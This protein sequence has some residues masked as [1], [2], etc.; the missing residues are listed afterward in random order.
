MFGNWIQIGFESKNPQAPHGGWLFGN[1]ILVLNSIPNIMLL[2]LKSNFYKTHL[3]CFIFWWVLGYLSIPIIKFVVGLLANPLIV[4]SRWVFVG[5]VV[6]GGGCGG[7][8]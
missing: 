5:F 1:C 2:I 8:C 7:F 6:V 4:F 3:M